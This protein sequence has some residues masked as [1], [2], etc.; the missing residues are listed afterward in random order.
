MNSLS[1]AGGFSSGSRT[2]GKRHYSPGC[3]V[4]EFVAASRLS[5]L[6]AL[7]DTVRR[8]GVTNC[9]C[10]EPAGCLRIPVRRLSLSAFSD[11]GRSLAL[12]ERHG[13]YGRTK[14]AYHDHDFWS[15]SFCGQAGSS[16]CRKATDWQSFS[17]HYVIVR[18]SITC[19]TPG[20][21]VSSWRT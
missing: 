9:T 14:K 11:S 15:L 17:W 1:R 8:A 19:G 16:F 10:F 21:S 3:D 20:A 5:L 12:N 13:Y 6:S 7:I 18:T 2:A 4:F